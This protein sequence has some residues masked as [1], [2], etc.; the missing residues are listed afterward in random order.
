MALNIADLAEHA[1]DA[2]PNRVALICQDERLTYA[3]LEDKA[4][5]FAHYLI[6]REVEPDDKVG[7]Y[8]RNRIEMVIAMLGI[9]KAGAIPVSL[10]YGSTE[11]EIRYIINDSEAVALVHERRYSERIA[12][13]LPN[14]PRVHTVLAVEDGSNDDYQGHGGQEF[15]SAIESCSPVRDFPERSSDAIYVIYTGR[16]TGFPEGVMWRHEDIYQALI[17]STDFGTGDP[18]PGELELSRQAAANP[19]MTGYPIPPMTHGATQSATWMSLFCGQTMVLSP[20][21]EPHDVWRTVEKLKVN[22][23][24]FAG[25][26]TVRHLLDALVIAQE[27]LEPYDLSSLYLLA[28][29]GARFSP[30]LKAELL[31]QLPNRIIT[32]SIGSSETGF[33]GISIVTAGEHHC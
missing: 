8:C 11:A 28:S 19:P 25:D 29:S 17:G 20:E 2:V 33:G 16:T 31:A 3:E 5:R 14:T 26:A 30:N 6:D 24:F 22:M 23:I 21:F 27:H 10:N 18:L 4:N 32:N 9:V 1:I 7:L 15:H 12:N 13:V